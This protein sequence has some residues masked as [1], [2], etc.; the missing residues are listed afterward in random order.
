MFILFRLNLSY[1]VLHFCRYH[2]HLANHLPV[3]KRGYFILFICVL[4]YLFICLF[5]YLFNL[6]IT[7]EDDTVL[8]ITII[9]SFQQNWAI[10]FR[11]P[12]MQMS[13]LAFQ[14]VTRNSSSH[15]NIA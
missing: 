9:V 15:I 4:T 10:D 8:F 14:S 3:V 5:I 2:L 12:L 11:F 6:F 13:V 1:P 7:R